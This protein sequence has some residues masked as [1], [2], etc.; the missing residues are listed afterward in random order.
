MNL[1]F[2]NST[3]RWGGVKTWTLR[4]ARGLRARGHGVLVAGREGDPFLDACREAGLEALGLPFGASWSP[5][6][7]ARFWRLIGRRGIDLV[8]CN[9]GRDLSTAGA[10]ARLRGRPVVHR[11]GMVR[12]FRDTLSRRT[13]QRVLQARF[14]VPAEH[15]ARGLSERFAW[16]A[17]ADV[18]VSANACRSLA[19]RAEPGREPA[20]VLCLARL[21]PGKGQRDLLRAAARLSGEG[22]EFTVRL[23]GAGEDEQPLRALAVSL[24][25]ADRVVFAG[26]VADV[27]KELAGA[28]IGV[29]ASHDEGFPNQLIEGLGAGLAMVATDLPAVR[30]AL[31]GEAAARLVP[32]GDAGALADAL[33]AL[34]RDPAART[35]LGEAGRRRAEAAFS[36][37]AEAER[38][39]GLF[40]GILAERPRR[41][42]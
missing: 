3:R 25:L 31:G 1:L 7:I 4:A 34:L 38:L 36:P 10:A 8:V 32:A 29:L 22:L 21:H 14:L 13:A 41:G 5:L 26:F 27:E 28:Q 15:M 30:E 16:I 2:V 40:E 6:L 23:A 19:A 24:G 39:E 9:T 20:T 33:G 11:V 12:D 17:P 37:R 18:L 42:A 35:R